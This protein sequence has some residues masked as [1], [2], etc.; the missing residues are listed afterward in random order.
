MLLG[1]VGASR[2]L[3]YKWNN[4]GHYARPLSQRISTVILDEAGA[5]P[6]HRLPVLIALRPIRLLLV[7]DHKQL[8]PYTECQEG[9]QPRSLLQRVAEA[10]EAAGGNALPMLRTQYRMHPAVARSVSD[11]FYGGR[12]RTDAGVVA[13]RMAPAK[14]A[15]PGSEFSAAGLQWL[16]Y[17]SNKTGREEIRDSSRSWKNPKEV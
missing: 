14:L 5:V 17:H 8:P 12:I 16:D 7:G 15:W 3:H 1:T 13:E 4:R 2:N 9:P 10:V 11:A 6:E